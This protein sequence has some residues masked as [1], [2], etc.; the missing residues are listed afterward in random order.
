MAEEF[1]KL[2]RDRIP[3]VIKENGEE[4][5]IH[6]AD[7]DEYSERLAE[8]LDEEATEYLE[9]REVSE[10]ADVL[11][12]VHAI[13]KDRGVTLEELQEIRTQKAKERGRFDEGIVLER[14]KK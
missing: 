10:L 14:V 4:P 5:T 1:D 2:V 3:Q 11:E 9:S 13:R 8:K 12:V 7:G 6:H